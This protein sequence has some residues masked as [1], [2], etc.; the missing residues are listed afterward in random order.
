MLLVY[1]SLMLQCIALN[2]NNLFFFVSVPIHSIGWFCL[3]YW[4]IDRY[5]CSRD[6]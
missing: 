3:S 6:V 1:L 5:D 4:T 2:L